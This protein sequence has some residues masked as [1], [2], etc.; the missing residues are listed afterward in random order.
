MLMFSSR[1]LSLWVLQSGEKKK[2]KSTLPCIST[3]FAKLCSPIP[4]TPATFHHLLIRAERRL[5]LVRDM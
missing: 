1:V 5:L 4:C 2:L 3:V